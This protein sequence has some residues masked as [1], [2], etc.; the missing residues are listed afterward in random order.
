MLKLTEAYHIHILYN[1][2]LGFTESDS[3]FKDETSEVVNW[4]D[5]M[6]QTT[7]SSG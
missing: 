4:N 5:G 2:Y 6:L 3:D 1:S 7:H